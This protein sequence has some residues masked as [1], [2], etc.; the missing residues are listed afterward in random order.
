MV[1]QHFWIH[2]NHSTVIQ[3][4]DQILEY[5]VYKNT[6]KSN[7][8]SNIV[9]FYFNEIYINIGCFF[10]VFLCWCSLRMFYYYYFCIRSFA[11]SF[12][13]TYL[14]KIYNICC[15]GCVN[16]LRNFSLCSELQKM[17]VLCIFMYVV[18]NCLDSS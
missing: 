15:R 7:Q 1:Q 9:L 14:L 17:N 16:L 6:S 5:T 11:C 3:S 2:L 13:Y 18:N 4:C 12:A 10:P 8:K